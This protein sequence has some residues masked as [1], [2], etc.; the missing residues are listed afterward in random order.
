MFLSQYLI[1]IKNRF[2]LVFFSCICTIIT[3]CFYKEILLISII[4]PTLNTN[5]YFNGNLY[6]IFTD[7]KELFNVYVYLIFFVNNQ[8][9]VFILLYHLFMF[10]YLGLY[11]VEYQKIKKTIKTIWIFF[12]VA[13]F[14]SYYFIIPISWYFFLNL[15]NK[16]NNTN[17]VSFFF[18]A[19]ISEYFDFVYQ[20][21]ILSVLSFQ[22]LGISML[23]LNNLFVEIKNTEIKF[24]RKLLYFCF[25]LFSTVVTPPD[26]F[27]QI[28]VSFFLI[29]CLEAFIFIKILN[30][31]KSKN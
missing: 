9:C 19:K 18:E 14:T 26:L 13:V 21:Y 11:T 2:F 29:L 28:I 31:F 17:L 5:C 27:S 24:S 8:A 25:V 4:K 20:V 12:F 30:S 3:C 7:V 6:F 10:I 22:A 15:Q 16:T 23:V 1:E